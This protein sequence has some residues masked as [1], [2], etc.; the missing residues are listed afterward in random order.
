MDVC[1]CLIF[2]DECNILSSF[3]LDS[4][5]PLGNGSAV[6]GI[7]AFRQRLFVAVENSADISVYDSTTFTLQKRLSV[8]GLK[9]T[10]DMALSPSAGFLYVADWDSRA[11]FQVETERTQQKAKKWST[12]GDFGGISIIPGTGH[13]LFSGHDRSSLKEFSHRGDVV[14]ELKIRSD[15]NEAI[16]PW[17]ALQLSADQ[18]LVSHG[19]SSPGALHRVCVVNAEGCV[20][21]SFGD[22]RGRAPDRLFG[23]YHLALDS[24]GTVLVVDCNNSRIVALDRDLK[25]LKEFSN[26]FRKPRRISFDPTNSKFYATDNTL[27]DKKASDGK[28]LEFS[29]NYERNEV[30]SNY[31]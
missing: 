29:L 1:L 16:R 30:E 15:V 2:S 5:L 8:F 21:R 3:S 26:V 12:G 7:A 22:L 24:K 11:I 25:F 31:N 9:Q 10:S 20:V 18:F 4:N 17:H 19:G 28:L 13:L 14:K 27:K 6:L 23:P